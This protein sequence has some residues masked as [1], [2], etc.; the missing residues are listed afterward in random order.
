[1]TIAMSCCLIGAW[2]I[3]DQH[4]EGRE[5]D[6]GDIKVSNKINDLCG[7]CVAYYLVMDLGIYVIFKFWKHAN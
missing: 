1:M 3:L 2:T 7:T 4:Q 5:G 6:K